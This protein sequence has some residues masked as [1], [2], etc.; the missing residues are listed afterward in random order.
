[1]DLSQLAKISWLMEP[2]P[3]PEGPYF[4]SVIPL[5]ILVFFALYLWF[6]SKNRFYVL[7]RLYRWI[8]CWLFVSGLIGLILIFCRWQSIPYFNSRLV[9]LFLIVIFTAWGIFIF[10][11]QGVKLPGE[12]RRKNEQKKFDQYLPKKKVFKK[13]SRRK[14]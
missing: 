3:N 5:S 9:F 8:A 4:Y 12:I 6:K 2:N 14:I 10:L 7:K 11:S 1:M 13:E